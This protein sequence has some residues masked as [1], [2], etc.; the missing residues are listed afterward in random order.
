MRNSVSYRAPGSLSPRGEPSANHGS[1]NRELSRL[2]ALL[3]AKH[4]TRYSGSA[5]AEFQKRVSKN[6]L[7][8]PLRSCAVSAWA[9]DLCSNLVN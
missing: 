5:A 1:Q 3:I 6:K 2:T 7:S 4:T 8:S 9:F